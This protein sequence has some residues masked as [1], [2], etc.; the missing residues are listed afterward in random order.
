MGGVGIFPRRRTTHCRCEPRDALRR[1]T[2]QS[3]ALR[4]RGSSPT[5]MHAL[6]DSHAPLFT[7]ASTAND[8]HATLSLRDRSAD[9]GPYGWFVHLRLDRER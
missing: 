3:C 1:R 9:S 2:N 8:S 4:L 6:G 7:G 5:Q